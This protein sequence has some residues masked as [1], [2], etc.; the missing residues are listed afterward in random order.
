MEN[1]YT[2]LYLLTIIADASGNFTIH[3]Y[4]TTLYLFLVFWVIYVKSFDLHSADADFS[5]AMIH[6]K[7]L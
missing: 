2:L 1:N 5:A 4:Q 3:F 7:A 6:F